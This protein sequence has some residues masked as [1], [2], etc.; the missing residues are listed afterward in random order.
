ML[1]H[2]IESSTTF[3]QG[4]Q[5]GLIPQHLAEKVRYVL[6]GS[7][8]GLEVGNIIGTVALN[9]GD[10]LHIR[11]KVGEVNFFRML[12]ICEGIASNLAADF[13]DFAGYESSDET[14]VSLLVARRFLYELHYILK[15][16]L[17][18][19]RRK[20]AQ[21]RQFAE[22]KIMPV[23]TIRNIQRR[24]AF[25]VATLVS[26]R[27]FDTPEH[28]I[29]A[30]A[31]KRALSY[32]K[33]SEITP[34]IASAQYW[35]KRFSGSRS[36]SQDL[37]EVNRKLRKSRYTGVRGY[38]VK[39]LALAKII[40]G[41]SGFTQGDAE[42]IYGDSVLIN[43]ATLFEEYIRGVIELRYHPRGFSVRKGGHPSEFLYVDGTYR[44]IPD[45]CI[46]KGS[47]QVLIGDA[48][49]KLPDAKDHYQILSYMRSYGLSTG[50]IF[51]PNFSENHPVVSE[52]KTLRGERVFEIYLPLSDLDTTE[53]FLGQLQEYVHLGD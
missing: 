11:P 36:L 37:A 10:T 41:E 15:A 20:V 18:F 40:L 7:A 14:P 51:A 16:S 34:H 4:F 44:L 8:T 45:I 35:V 6:K 24:A 33:I 21:E 12:L 13:D 9:N 46:F 22:G 43:S 17:R 39:T 38:Y 42:E 3:L 26:I 29:L 19:E 2:V 28:R 23:K 47:S 48:K 1:W 50:V 5:P 52:K 27:E 25:P 31:A 53:K 32:I 49:Y 30:E